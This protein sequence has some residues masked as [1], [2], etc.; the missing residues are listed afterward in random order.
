MLH[1]LQ[2]RIAALR[3]RVR[4]LVLLYALS[5]VV[6]GVLAA[7]VVLGLADYLFRFQDPGLRLMASLAALAVVGWTGYRFLYRGLAARL[8]DLDLARRLQRRFPHLGD[9]LASA[10]EFLGQSRED[11]ASGSTTLRDAVVGRTTAAVKKLD[12]RASLRLGPVRRAAAIAGTCLMA[13]GILV[14]LNPSGCGTALARLAS[15]F[16]ETSWPRVHHLEIRQ[17][18]PQRVN[19]GGTFRVTVVDAPGVALPAEVFIHYRFDGP[20]GPSVETARMS[21]LGGMMVAQRENVTRPCSF[22]VEGGDDDSME[23]LPIE[24]VDRPAVKSVVIRLFPPPYT[25]WPVEQTEKNVHA[26]VGTRLEVSAVATK[27]LASAV[28]CLDG[29]RVPGRVAQDGLSFQVPADAGHGCVVTKSGPYWFELTDREE[30]TGEEKVLGEIQAVPDVPPSVNVDE[31]E[32]NVYVT[33]EAVVPV[34]VTARDDLAIREVVLAWNR[35]DQPDGPDARVSLHSGPAAALP[36]A[37]GLAAAASGDQRTVSYRWSLAS[38]RLQPGAQ[39]TY[40]AAASD[41][42]P[43]T[44]KS[45]S[46]RL[47]V[48]TSEEMADRVVARQSA[49]LSELSRVLAMQR[50]TREQVAASEILLQAKQRPDQS[51]MGN[52]ANAERNQREV[53]RLLAGTGEG[54]RTLVLGLLADLENNQVDSPDVKRWMQSLRAEIDRLARED[55][56]A[57]G[58]ELTAAV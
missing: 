14:A 54:V 8:S 50:Q 15:P 23:W 39:V 12:F 25:G 6:S 37:G 52:L 26:L 36:K 1:P 44:G 27:P 17:P 21:P 48:V 51:D 5:W 13:A 40:W 46:R 31:P 16:G 42:R 45:P 53:T 29:I 58:L 41:Y 19:R 57:I 24:V 56:A 20:E 28:L 35:S 30:L 9:S 55:L 3:S 7:V 22:R 10:V 32:A 18:A 34:R 4:R 38:L 43:Q 33:P 47:T 49:I 2:Q 11:P